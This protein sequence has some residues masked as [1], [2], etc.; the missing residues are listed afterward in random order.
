MS[1]LIDSKDREEF[2]VLR[3]RPTS[4]AHLFAPAPFVVS[5]VSTMVV[6]TVG[7]S[8]WLNLCFSWYRPW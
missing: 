2:S 4:L 8:Q 6:V 5:T 3:E 7:R 1:Y